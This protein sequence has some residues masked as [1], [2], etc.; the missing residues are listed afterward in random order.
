VVG[1]G[2]SA[3]EPASSGP[4]T[5]LSWSFIQLVSQPVSEPYLISMRCA[6]FGNCMHVC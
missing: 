2:I 4:V 1:F 3:V 5:R 6:C